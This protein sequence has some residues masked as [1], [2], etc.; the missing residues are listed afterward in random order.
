MEIMEAPEDMAEAERAEEET[1]ELA[2]TV[3]VEPQEELEDQDL[4]LMLVVQAGPVEP[5]T[6]VRSTMR[7]V[8][9]LP[10]M[11]RPE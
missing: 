4:L 1:G 7:P 10:S 5:A 9:R 2:P 3:V 11:D 8:E 6:A